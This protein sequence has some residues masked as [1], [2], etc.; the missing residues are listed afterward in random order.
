[1]LIR[2]SLVQFQDLVLVSL[3]WPDFIVSWENLTLVSQTTQ[4][5][6]KT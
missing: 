2:T 3:D 4:A 1:M 6:P 5:N